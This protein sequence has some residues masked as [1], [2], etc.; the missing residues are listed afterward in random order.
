M[1][2]HRPPSFFLTSI[3]TLHHG[4]CLG[5]IVPT[6]SI[7]FMWALTSS[8]IGGGIF[9]NL[10]LNDSLLTTQISCY[11][12]LMHPTLQVLVRRHHGTPGAGHDQMCS[13][14]QTILQSWQIL[15]LD[16]HFLSPFNSYLGP[17]DSL[18]FI[19][20]F[21]CSRYNFYRGT[22]FAATTQVILMPLP[23]V[24]GAVV[25]FLITMATHLLPVV[26]LM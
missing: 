2:K 3:T 16:E 20:P 24:I 14:L 6:S 4:L 19:Q 18:Y 1:Q 8:T 10:S 13:L 25:L 9:W 26:I 17:L 11:M 12:R 22:L 5:C 7:S 23:I 21:Q 15:L